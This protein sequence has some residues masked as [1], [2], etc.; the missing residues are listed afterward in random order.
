MSCLKK[1]NLFFLT[2]VKKNYTNFM[3]SANEINVLKNIEGKGLRIS[4]SEDLTGTT[5]LNS[6]LE[7]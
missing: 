1:K 3:F 4:Y 5:A 6:L 7:I 2:K